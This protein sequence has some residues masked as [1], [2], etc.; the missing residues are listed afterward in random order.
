MKGTTK[1]HHWF[2]WLVTNF[3]LNNVTKSFLVDVDDVTFSFN[4]TS[5]EVDETAVE[6]Q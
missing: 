3:G 6:I 4:R 1:F 2:G 5:V